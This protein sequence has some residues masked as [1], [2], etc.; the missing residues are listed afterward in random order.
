MVLIR[1]VVTSVL[2]LVASAVYCDDAIERYAD[3]C[4]SCHASQA[5]STEEQHAVIAGP[6]LGGFSDAYIKE[7]LRNFKQGR[8][9]AG[10]PGAVAMASAA[11]NLT[12]NDIKVLSNWAA[13]QKSK[14]LL[15]FN[16]SEDDKGAELY[17][18][19]C[20]GCHSSLLGRMFT[21]SPKLTYL[22]ADYIVSQLELFATGQRAVNSAN[23]HQSK[24]QQVVES[25]S[26]KQM[27]H[28]ASFIKQSQ[29]R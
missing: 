1:W 28:L 23:K 22:T 12:D 17:K 8:R 3:F 6:Q 7:Q 24:M 18:S 20:R 21:K 16:Y 9:G 5:Q 27:S 2:L 15:K 29:I 10:T 14:R 26:P 11:K 4:Q 13:S 25:L 19:Q